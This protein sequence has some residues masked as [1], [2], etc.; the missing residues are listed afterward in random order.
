MSLFI[1]WSLV[2]HG[3]VDGFSRLIIFLHCGGNNKSITVLQ[4][5]ESA[6][7]N[8]GIPERVRTDRGG[9]NIQVRV[10]SFG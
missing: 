5:F 2:V 4:L 10:C 7:Q 1:R 8:S 6:N 9:E 3:G